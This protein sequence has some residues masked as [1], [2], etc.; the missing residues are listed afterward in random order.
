VASAVVSIV[1]VGH[2][3]LAGNISGSL[4]M[5]LLDSRHQIHA[6][7]LFQVRQSEVIEYE[8]VRF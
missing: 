2:G 4:G 7:L 5:A 1:P 3:Q 8:Q 6:L